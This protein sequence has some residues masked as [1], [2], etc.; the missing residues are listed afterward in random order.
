MMI[1]Y[2][3]G[4]SYYT[5]IVLSCRYYDYISAASHHSITAFLVKIK[6]TFV[7]QHNAVISNEG[8][9]QQRNTTAVWYEWTLSLHLCTYTYTQ[10]ILNNK[11]NVDTVSSDKNFSLW[12]N[13]VTYL[14]KNG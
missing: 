7:Q 3:K 4:R 14:I 11:S 10:T 13:E 9:V 8:A 5:A 6:L 2:R 1:L 12:V